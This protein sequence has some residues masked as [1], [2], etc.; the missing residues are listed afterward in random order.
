MS[1]IFVGLDVGGTNVK[2]GLFDSELTMICK[3]S[4]TTEADMGPEV[5]INNMAQAVKELL[6]EAG[7]SLQDIVAVGIGTPGPAKY[8]EGII[9]RSTNM[10]KFKNVPICKMLNERLG[11]PVVYDNDANV[12][13]WG[14]YSVGA[15]KGVK[16]IAFFTLGTGIGGGIVS[17]GELVHGCNENGAELGHMIIY[18]DGRS[19]NCG[20]KGCVEAYA[21][22]DSTARRAT[23]AIEAGA[24]SSLKQ[25]LEEKG[26]ITSKDIYQHLASG[27]K[28]AKEITDGTAEALAITCINML[29]TTE[30][31]RIIFTGGM[32]AAG[33]VLLNRIKDFFDK[34]IWTLKKESVEICFATLGEDTGIIGAA[35]L[36]RHTKQQGKL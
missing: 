20:Q 34:H 28:L 2:I 16:D 25:V 24:E 22:A 8:S 31:K 23:E 18:P 9:I 15:G 33:D 17:N 21:S 26:K 12:A 10:P 35:A 5:V 29:H 3:T 6:A 27:D 4:I 30:P 11:A 19:C 14:E 32:I 1:E 36:A 7:L 13:C